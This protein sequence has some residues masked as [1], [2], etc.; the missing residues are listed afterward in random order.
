[1]NALF[2]MEQKDAK[3]RYKNLSAEILRHDELYHG[4]DN[5]E[6]SDADYDKLRRE[7]ESLEKEFPELKSKASKSVGA[8]PSRKFQKVE[9][10]VPMLSLS[11]VFS[12]EELEEFLDRVRRF[13][14]LSDDEVVEI[15]AE[16]KIDGLSCSLV[17]EKGRLATGVTRGDGYVGEDITENVKTIADIPHE[18]K[19][20]IPDRL[21][22][23]GEIYMRRDDFVTLNARLEKE[24]KPVFANPRNAA[25]GSV[26]Q[27]NSEITK[28]RALSFFGYALGENKAV[29][30]DTQEGVRNHLKSWGFPQAEPSGLCK[31][32]KEIMA[33]YENLEEIRPDLPYEI[34]G[35]VYKVNRLDWQ[36]R[37]GFVSRAPR[38]ATAHKFPAEK[39][40]T[41]LRDIEIQVGRTG[42]LTPVARLEPITVGGVV[43]SNATLHNEDE[44]ERKGVKIGDHVEIQRA[45]DVI[46]Q[47][48]RVIMDKRP[49]DA[50]DFMFPTRC[51]ICDSLAIREEGEVKRR[52][53]GGLI[54]SAQAVERLKHFVSKGAFDIEGMG[55]KVV[56]QFYL[57]E[58]IKTPVD[59]FTLEQRNPSF[60]PSLEEREGW[61]ELSAQNLFKAI[62]AKKT[63]SLN[64]FIYAL[65][66]R[67][68]GEATAKRLATRY[69]TFKNLKTEMI[70][71]S[72]KD[73]GA[74]AELINID[75][76]GPAVADDLIGFFAEAHNL[77]VTD[78]LTD[79]LTIQSYEA[80]NV[81]DSPVAGKTV[82]FT[83]TLE[84]MSR[85]EAKARA[86]SLG[87]KVAGSVSQKTDYV[88]AG[89]AAGSKRKKAEELG[90]EILSED[91]WLKLIEV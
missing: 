55:A 79:L 25:A 83:G 37:L 9:H 49:K 56:E 5:P 73:G 36:E 16:P 19:G 3:A 57:D 24:G 21:E 58:I 14:S 31:N 65:G 85:A 54:C 90:V 38:W 26:R 43:V 23:R 15:I 12:E 6:I 91:D 61:G 18:I 47:I 72:D 67:Q 51:P 30:E 17:Y 39:A 10:S 69:T 66:I 13:L 34:D 60:E 8:S 7:L 33:L 46:P 29:V 48:V 28:S 11:N 88:V 81:S 80:V 20:D 59:I 44:I 70:K 78:K 87:A 50:K 41:I 45:G 62:D 89:E 2:N 42:A 52:C 22:V 40:I 63:V 4:E 64:R 32:A 76:I 68:V 75:D 27:L 71:A 35:V 1:M 86:E 74:Y 53:T 84:K 82:V 77:E